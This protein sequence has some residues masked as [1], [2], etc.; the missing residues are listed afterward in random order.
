MQ[1]I[2]VA[3]PPSYAHIESLS[4]DEDDGNENGKKKQ[5]VYISKNN[6]F[7][8]ASRF[9]YISL[10]SLHDYNEKVPKFT[11]LEDMNTRQR[12]PFSFPEL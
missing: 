4:N 7:A 12:L 2:V 10:P 3:L 1:S 11:F 8:R 6:N 9:L 5:E